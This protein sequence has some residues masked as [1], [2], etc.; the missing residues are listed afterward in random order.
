[1]KTGI[2]AIKPTQT[3]NINKDAM[4]YFSIAQGYLAGGMNNFGDDRDAAKFDEQTSL[5]YEFGAKP[6]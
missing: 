2:P 4:I 5:N 6:G 1:M 3:L